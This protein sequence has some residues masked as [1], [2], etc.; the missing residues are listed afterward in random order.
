MCQCCD[1]V[2]CC[3]VLCC[4]VL[5]CVVLCC[6][7]LCCVLRLVVRWDSSVGAVG[8]VVRLADG[9]EKLQGTSRGGNKLIC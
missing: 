4:V 6:V 9:S 7:V 8:A 5:C 2:L 3:V 1:V